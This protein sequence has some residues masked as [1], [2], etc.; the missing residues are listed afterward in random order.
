MDILEIEQKE[1]LGREHVAERL[2]TLADMLARH[3]DLEF[4]RGG[5]R[6]TL[7]VPD[8]VQLKIELEVETD[9]RE[10]EIELKW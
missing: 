8:Q 6:F 5:M 9:E 10:L 3:N 4:E 7:H 1:T 2:R